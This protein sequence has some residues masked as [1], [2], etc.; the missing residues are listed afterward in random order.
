MGLVFSVL[1]CCGTCVK[2]CSSCCCS[3]GKGAAAGSRQASKASYVCLLF[4]STLVSWVVQRYG[5]DGDKSFAELDFECTGADGNLVCS[6]NGFV[7]RVSFVNV[8]FFSL[9][10]LLTTNVPTCTG[11]RSWRPIAGDSFHLG[12]WSVKLVIYFGLM[13]MVP[14]LPS[15]FW[16]DDENAYAWVARVVSGF[17]LL[18]QVLLLIDF[19][20]AL[21]DDWVERAGDEM[22]NK[23]WIYGL[24]AITAVLL[25]G[26]LGGNAFLFLK[27][28]GCSQAATF[29]G[30]NVGF[31]VVYMA[32][33]LFRDRYADN[34][35]AVLPTVLVFFYTTFLVWS[36]TE[37]IP[38]SSCRPFDDGSDLVVFVGVLIAALSLSWLSYT[39][40][41]RTTKLVTGGGAGES[42]GGAGMGGIYAVGSDSGGRDVL[43]RDG[44]SDAGEASSN[45][46]DALPDKTHIFYGILIL[47]SFYMAMLLTNW[48]TDN[49]FNTNAAIGNI[50]SSV[51]FASA[52]FTIALYTWTLVAPAVLKNREFDF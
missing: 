31:F 16:D 18:L 6:D 45:P 3:V 29:A 46:N 44:D 1:C 14:F 2:S 49:G 26:A 34:P 11:D 37:S 22:E 33:T 52:G 35:G 23:G 36:G 15:S 19:G 4:L 27:Y 51:K 28:D 7:L 43:A 20:Y 32:L 12:W 50:S 30:L 21:N 8:L 47:A 42:S 38:D 9:M 24:I 41:S 10:M 17:F 48:G 5:E 25:A 40:S 39:A 13:V